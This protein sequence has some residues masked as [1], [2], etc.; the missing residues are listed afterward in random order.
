[1]F[2]IIKRE[3]NNL[4]LHLKKL[5]LVKIKDL[6][7]EFFISFIAP[8]LNTIFDLFINNEI[9]AITNLSIRHYHYNDQM[10]TEFN[11]KKLKYHS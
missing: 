1:M 4:L 10:L 7:G 6:K 8:E 9:I 5:C 11:K 3:K 2:S